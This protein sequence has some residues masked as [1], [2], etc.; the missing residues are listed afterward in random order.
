MA[1]AEHILTFTDPRKAIHYIKEHCTNQHAASA[2]CPDLI[3]LDI[4]MPGMN[5]FDF[6]EEVKAI[7]QNDLIRKVTIALS[8]S[9]SPKDRNKMA[10]YGVKG[11]LSKPLTEQNLLEA[12][13]KQA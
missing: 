13:D 5:G 8:S 2:E 1:A 4:N 3:L 6:L 11:Y 12:L 10:E 7:G 9:S